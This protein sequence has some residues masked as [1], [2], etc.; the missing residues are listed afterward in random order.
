MPGCEG[1]VDVAR[2]VVGEMYAA[3]E[4]LLAELLR[5]PLETSPAIA[6]EALAWTLVYA[7][8]GSKDT[9]ATAEDMRRLV[10]SEDDLVVAALRR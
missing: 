1:S 4:P 8:L 6:P 3:F 7:M 5:D 2:P 9:A 10:S